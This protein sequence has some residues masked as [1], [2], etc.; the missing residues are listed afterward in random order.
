MVLS[1]PTHALLE[2]I[3]TANTAKHAL[4]LLEPLE[5]NFAREQRIQLMCANITLL[6]QVAETAKQHL[7]NLALV[8]RTTKQVFSQVKLTL[9][10]TAVPMADLTAMTVE[11]KMFAVMATEIATRVSKEAVKTKAAELLN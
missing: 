8:T 10:P 11:L 4:L 6:S 1:V 5:Q 3:V 9:I 7:L 2:T